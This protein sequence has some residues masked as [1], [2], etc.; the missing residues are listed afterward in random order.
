MAEIRATGGWPTFTFF[1]KVGTIRLAVTAFLCHDDYA[2][3]VPNHPRRYYGTKELH[4]ITCSGYH[5]QSWLAS[6][7]RRDLFLAVLE[8]VRQRYG[9]VVVG[10]VVMPDHIHLL[11]SEP[12]KGDPSRVMQAVKQGFSRRVL[13]AVHKRRVAAQGNCS[14]SGLSMSGSAA[15]MISTCGQSVSGSRSCAICTAIRWREGWCRKPGN[16]GGAAIGVMLSGKRARCESISGA[17]PR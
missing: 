13:K 15:F 2:D 1:V 10:Y 12:E 5:R 4:F 17:R 7:K 11:I 16:G 3:C 14:R 9:F 6:P 8:E